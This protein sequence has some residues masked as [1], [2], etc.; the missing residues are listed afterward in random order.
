MINVVFLLVIFFMMSARI[1]PAPPFDV[2]LPRSDSDSA[3]REESTFYLS[4]DGN[5]A[6]GG[7]TGDDAWAALARADT[8]RSLTI[9]ADAQLAT[10]K[11]A[12]VLTQL[13]KLEITSVTLAVRAQ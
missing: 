2:E 7:V 3:V 12:A 11:L 10:P 13:A 6:F 5:V 4:A 8:A 9:R 1:A